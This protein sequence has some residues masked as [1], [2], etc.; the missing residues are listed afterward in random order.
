MENQSG[1]VPYDVERAE[2]EAEARRLGVDL[3]M[4]AELIIMLRQAK[5]DV[6]ILTGA[7]RPR[8]DVIIYPRRKRGPAGAMWQ[9]RCRQKA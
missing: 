6:D 1:I 2:I 3:P 8:E 4:P 5:L 7:I 9:R